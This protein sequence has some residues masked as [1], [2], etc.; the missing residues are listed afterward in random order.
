MGPYLGLVI[1][2]P[3]ALSAGLARASGAASRPLPLTQERERRGGSRGP[4]PRSPQQE[5]S[6]PSL[7]TTD[8]SSPPPSD[9]QSP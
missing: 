9:L 7:T 4:L 2:N 1:E 8:W 3:G 6:L 5:R